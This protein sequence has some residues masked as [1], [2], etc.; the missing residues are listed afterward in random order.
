MYCGLVELWRILTS[1]VNFFI[2]WFR[3]FCRQCFISFHSTLMESLVLIVLCALKKQEIIIT[4]QLRILKCSQ[5]PPSGNYFV[6]Y[7][8]KL[9]SIIY[10]LYTICTYSSEENAMGSTIPKAKQQEWGRRK[11]R[12]NMQD[13]NANDLRNDLCKKS[14]EGEIRDVVAMWAAKQ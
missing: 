6:N 1:L 8:Y 10:N 12:D 7:L 5:A 4:T 14:V 9:A 3:V 11:N 13:V 2:G